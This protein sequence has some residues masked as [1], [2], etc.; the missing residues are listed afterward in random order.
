MIKEL[1]KSGIIDDIIKIAQLKEMSALNK[2]D[3]KKT[4]SIRGLTKLDD[5]EWAGTNKSKQCRLI[6]TEGDSAKTF[7][8]SGLEVIGR[9]K[10]G[11]F[12]LRGKLLNVRDASITQLTNNEEIKNIKLILGL[13]QKKKYSENDLS[14]L[15]YG[16]II[17]LTDQDVDGSHIKGLLI[18]FFH[19]FWPSLVKIN[20][21]IQCMKTP[22]I[23]IFKNSDLKK[24]NPIIFYTITEYKQW[25]DDHNHLLSN[26]TIKYYKGLGTSTDSEASEAFIDF[27]NKLIN[28]VWSHEEPIL[29]SPIENKDDTIS[30]DTPIK[31]ND[32]KETTQEDDELDLNSKS[33]NAI[34]LAFSKH[35]ANDRKKWLERYNPNL[36][37]EIDMIYY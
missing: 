9:D 22:I 26:Y 36:I 11:V 20:G 10:Y 35:R 19:Y 14:K 23:K 21:F 32:D 27:E 15:R 29:C 18:N 31:D 1:A 4:T 17:I 30:N 25:C 13:K 2:T 16:G 5:A 12:P 8:L 7:A 6:L 3:G 24:K 34:T 37:L 28:F 33:Y